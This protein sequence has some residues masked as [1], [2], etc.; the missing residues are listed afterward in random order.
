M[1]KQETQTISHTLCEYIKNTYQA[2]GAFVQG[3]T[4]HEARSER[5]TAYIF[6]RTHALALRAFTLHAVVVFLLLGDGASSSDGPRE[7]PQSA[8]PVQYL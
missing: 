8:C 2:K 4:I 7:A 5:D 1:K 6:T 3:I